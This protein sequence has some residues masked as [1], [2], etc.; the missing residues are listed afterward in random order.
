MASK[1]RLVLYLR[2][3]ERQSRRKAAR[4]EAGCRITRPELF[5]GASNGRNKQAIGFIELTP[6]MPAGGMNEGGR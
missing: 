3:H 4:R 6:D 1:K 2:C 5:G